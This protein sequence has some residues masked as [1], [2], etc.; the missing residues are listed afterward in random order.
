MLWFYKG[1]AKQNIQFKAGK[2][3]NVTSKGQ[4]SLV[5]IDT[6]GHIL[7]TITIDNL[8]KQDKKEAYYFI[9]VDSFF[10]RY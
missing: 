9:N 8:S 10:D 4:F 1:L 7:A 3:W 2:Y 5:E 6:S